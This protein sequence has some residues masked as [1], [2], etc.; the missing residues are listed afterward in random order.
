MVD[1]LQGRITELTAELNQY[2]PA[3]AKAK[4][5]ATRLQGVE[6]DLNRTV[7]SLRSEMAALER[8]HLADIAAVAATRDGLLAERDAAVAARE[9]LQAERDEAVAARD[10]IRRDRDEHVAKYEDLEK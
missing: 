9:V 6:T 3:L 1:D 2:G 7:Q 4:E 8:K 10:S 5:E